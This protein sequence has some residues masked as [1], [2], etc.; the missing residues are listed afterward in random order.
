MKA[1]DWARILSTGEI[2][3]VVRVYSVPKGSTG[4]RGLCLYTADGPP[5]KKFRYLL[6]SAVAQVSELELLAL[7][8]TESA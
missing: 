7:K 4:H 6:L 8:G 2:G 3:R 1:K 5:E